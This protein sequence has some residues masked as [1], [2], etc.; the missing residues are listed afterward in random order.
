MT[1]EPCV[2]L[3]VEEVGSIESVTVEVDSVLAAI[4]GETV[5]T[6]E[7]SAVETT[8]EEKK[9]SGLS[10]GVIAAIAIAAIVVVAVVVG[11]VLFVNSKETKPVADDDDNLFATTEGEETSDY[12]VHKI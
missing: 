1:G 11:A 6:S 2:A 5:V 9:D 12:N 3:L 4:T 7:M 8:P 10:T